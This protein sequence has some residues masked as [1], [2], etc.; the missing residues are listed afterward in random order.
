MR[1]GLLIGLVLGAAAASVVWL[2]I[3]RFAHHVTF[4]PVVGPDGSDGSIAYSPDVFGLPQWPGVA[5]ELESGAE[6]PLR[7]DPTQGWAVVDGALADGTGVSFVVDTAAEMSFVTVAGLARAGIEDVA[8]VPARRQT[9]EGFGGRFLV[10]MLALDA[11]TFGPHRF[12]PLP[13]VVLDLGGGLGPHLG[14]LGMLGVP[15]LDL[16]Q[17]RRVL[18][19]HADPP[20]GLGGGLPLQG[21]GVPRVPGTLGGHGVLVTLD[22]GGAFSAVSPALAEALD[23]PPGDRTFPATGADGVRRVQPGVRVS[24]LRIGDQVIDAQMA[25]GG[26]PS[27]AGE[28]VV[29]LGNDVLGT[30]RLVI[31]QGGR[32]AWLR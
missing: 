1:R 21:A 23:L 24:G 10:R 5:P 28:P 7:R 13:A 16:D 17:E 27:S 8:V 22:T 31:D 2:W 20:P 12:A 26:T 18:G 11:V 29:N 14:A 15:V 19:L 3:A 4:V 25:V 9:N 30:R 6:I 32:R